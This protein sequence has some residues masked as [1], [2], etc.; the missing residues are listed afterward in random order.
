M[1]SWKSL[2][3]SLASARHRNTK[4]HQ[5]WVC[6]W[7]R[8]ERHYWLPLE[9]GRRSDEGPQRLRLVRLLLPCIH[10]TCHFHSWRHVVHV[11]GIFM[12]GTNR[13]W[14]AMT[15]QTVT[16][17]GKRTTRPHRRRAKAS[18]SAVRPRSRPSR[19]GRCTC[20]TT[21]G[22]YLRRWTATA[23]TG[24]WRRT[25]AWRFWVR[26]R[27]LLALTS[28]PR[29]LEA[30]GAMTSRLTTNSLKVVWIFTVPVQ[31]SID[32][33]SAGNSCGF[34]FLGSPEERKSVFRAFR[35]SSRKEHRVYD[36]D[37]P[38]VSFKYVC[39]DIK[40]IL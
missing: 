16:T 17:V 6:A 25:D 12:C 14:S 38:D 11:L 7:L 27:I 18:W 9:R 20:R 32:D 29:K 36:V 3:F 40:W 4:H 21:P 24:W 33:S 2:C 10:N 39:V 22:S 28:A 30:T 19:R 1:R 15:C 23:C 8:R 13:G 34:I 37:D 31:P 26:R 35:Y 5:L